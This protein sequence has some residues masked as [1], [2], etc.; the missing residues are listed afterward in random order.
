MNSDH[1]VIGFYSLPFGL[2]L[3]NGILGER[4]SSSIIRKLGNKLKEQM[5]IQAQLVR[6]RFGFY[7]TQA[8]AQKPKDPFLC[9]RTE[10]NKYENHIM[11]DICK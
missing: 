7:R 5:H 10:N 4:G 11:R 9:L 3:A 8:N 2:I 6:I 1:P